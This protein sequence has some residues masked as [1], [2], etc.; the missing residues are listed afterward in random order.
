MAW[1][2]LWRKK[3]WLDHGDVWCVDVD[4]GDD[5]DDDDDDHKSRVQMW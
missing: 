4:G 3:A 1:N 5:D 2:V